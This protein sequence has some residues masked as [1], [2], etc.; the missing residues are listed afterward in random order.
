[1]TAEE[2]QAAIAEVVNGSCWLQRDLGWGDCGSKMEAACLTAATMIWVQLNTKP[3]YSCNCVDSA[4]PTE[5]CCSS[6]KQDK[7]AKT[8]EACC[9]AEPL[10]ENPLDIKVEVAKQQKI[11]ETLGKAVGEINKRTMGLNIGE[12]SRLTDMDLRVPAGLGQVLAAMRENVAGQKSTEPQAPPIDEG[13][14][15]EVE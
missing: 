4:K 7:P 3:Q 11:L 2:Y 14:V 6:D 12:N 13:P 1:M 15:A 9:G 5:S 8:A 10:G